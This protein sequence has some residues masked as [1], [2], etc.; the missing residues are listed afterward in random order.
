MTIAEERSVVIPSGG[1]AEDDAAPSRGGPAP[2]ARTPRHR[3]SGGV[4]VVA[5]P[6]GAGKSSLCDAIT[7]E[8]F[9]GVSVLRLHHRPGFLPYS[10][11]TK[12]PVT[13]P[14]A[15]PPYKAPLS[16]LKSLY[17]FCDFLAGWHLRIRPHTRR[18]GW[19]LLERGWWDLTVD[20]RRYRL[21]ETPRLISLLGRF[22]PKAD[23]TVILEAPPDLLLQ[24]KQ[25]LPADELARQARS[26]RSSLP[27]DARVVY[28]DA[29]Q[30]I[31][32]LV[33]TVDLELPRRPDLRPSRTAEERWVQLPGTRSLGWLLPQAPRRTSVSSLR[34]YQPV[35]VKGR[36]CWEL[37]R[38]AAAAGG[39]R[40]LR[41]DRRLPRAVDPLL[42]HVP[43]GGTVAIAKAN[44]PA[45]YL[46][47]ILDELGKPFAM[48]KIA[49]DDA[50][51]RSLEL[52]R[53]ALMGF[54][55]FLSAPLSP[56]RVLGHADGILL[57]E[58]V[59]WRPRSRP[60]RLPEEVAFAL[61]RFDVAGP[62]GPGGT[63]G[64]AHGDFAPWNLMRTEAGWVLL[65]WEEAADAYPPFFDLFHYLVQAHALLGRPSRRD[66]AAGLAGDGWVGGAIR[67]Y[68]DGAGAD[69]S[70]ARARFRQYLS[71]SNERLDATDPAHRSALRA[72]SRLWTLGT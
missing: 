34:L 66:I 33:R 13:E 5:G 70:E 3:G 4:I 63:S 65:D 27:G 1:Q 47:L 19:V 49:T 43:P 30:P 20:P 15:E 71:Q 45:R 21:R 14:H 64:L 46:G 26:W 18:G 67:A 7:S 60:W 28:L 41:A 62:Q 31:Q 38:T 2:V 11:R 55:P 25:E 10:S 6:D 24:R 37:A 58:V 69:P 42:D 40:F 48:A 8:L 39:F 54:G 59:A 61:G 16:L 53:E 44:H 12:G 35:T 68:A 52:E 36:V 56:P 57:M 32:Q 22:L 17:I 50:S 23:L 51:R 9:A 29:S 72:R